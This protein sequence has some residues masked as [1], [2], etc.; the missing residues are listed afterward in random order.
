MRSGGCAV[1][2]GKNDQTK[3]APEVDRKPEEIAPPPMMAVSGFAPT[4][5]RYALSGLED[6][7]RE[8]P[9][10]RSQDP[11]VAIV[12]RIQLGNT[13]EGVQALR[14][15]VKLLDG[16]GERDQRRRLT[17]IEARQGSYLAASG[18]LTQFNG[19]VAAA[20]A[21]ALATLELGSLKL[22]FSAALVLHVLASAVLCWAARPINP[23]REPTPT[24]TFFAQ[25]A[26]VDHTFRNYRRGWRITMLA[27][28]VTA[29]AG[30]L[31]GLQILGIS[32]PVSLLLAQ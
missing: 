28:A 14:D 31:L 24:M 13:A 12:E 4:E 17:E 21:G 15:F 27:L 30:N 26:L 19:I 5:D 16:G 8:P 22:A 7:L 11:L 29:I 23:R 9:L 6:L 20:L 10:A 2:E 32:L 18:T 1:S 3:Q 25:V